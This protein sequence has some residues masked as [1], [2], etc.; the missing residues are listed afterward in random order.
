MLAGHRWRLVVVLEVIERVGCLG[1]DCRWAQRHRALLLQNRVHFFRAFILLVNTDLNS[2]RTIIGFPLVLSR[3]F[4]HHFTRR[5]WDHSF[6][7]FAL[8]QRYGSSCCNTATRVDNAFA[9]LSHADELSFL[10]TVWSTV[11]RAILAEPEP[12]SV[13]R[14]DVQG[15]QDSFWACYLLLRR[16]YYPILRLKLQTLLIQTSSQVIITANG[17]RSLV[18][19]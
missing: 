18:L 16:R 12:L 1:V 14:I 6:D 8:M 5:A 2:A 10:G 19:G 7:I 11:N 4:N 3:T 9:G 13:V 17:I 15:K